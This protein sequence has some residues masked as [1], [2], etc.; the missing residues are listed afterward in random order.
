LTAGQATMA[1]SWR[2]GGGKDMIQPLAFRGAA[3][4]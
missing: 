4:A 3:N 2:K 1:P